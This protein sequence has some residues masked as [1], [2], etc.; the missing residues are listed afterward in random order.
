MTGK[1]LRRC[2]NCGRFHAAYLLPAEDG[3]VRSYC[4]DCCDARIH[5]SPPHDAE[6]E[7][8]SLDSLDLE[9]DP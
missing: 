9:K 1:I 3:Q 5:A 6:K 2:D 4:Y 7:D 8:E